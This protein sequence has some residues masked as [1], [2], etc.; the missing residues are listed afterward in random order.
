MVF[1]KLN[2]TL[3]D[4]PNGVEEYPMFPGIDPNKIK[5]KTFETISI[6]VHLIENNKIKKTWHVEDWNLA[7][8]QAMG[9]PKTSLRPPVLP[10]NK[11]L[12]G[13]PKAAEI[14]Y[15]VAFTDALGEGQNMSYYFNAYHDD[16]QARPN[17]FDPK[18]GGNFYMS[19]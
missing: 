11:P 10:P 5:G 15:D 7:L 3:G 6:D 14:L 12:T 17:P 2:G 1:S 18:N 16:L 9:S 4:L 8:G 19:Y 13:V